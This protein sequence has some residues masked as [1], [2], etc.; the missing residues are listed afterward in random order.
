MTL[1]VRRFCFFADLVFLLFRFS[2][3]WSNL[4]CIIFTACDW[5]LF[6]DLFVTD[7]PPLSQP[8]ELIFCRFLYCLFFFT[9]RNASFSFNSRVSFFWCIHFA[10]MFI[11][12]ARLWSAWFSFRVSVMFPV[13][14]SRII[15]FVSSGFPFRLPAY[16]IEALGILCFSTPRHTVHKHCTGFYLASIDLLWLFHLGSLAIKALGADCL[17]CFTQQ[18]HSYGF[19]FR[20]AVRL[21]LHPSASP[22]FFVYC[23]FELCSEKDTIC[24]HF[25]FFPY[26]FDLKQLTF[27]SLIFSINILIYGALRKTYFFILSFLNFSALLSSTII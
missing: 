6:L 27:F 12:F 5:L 25:R 23:L 26:D 3:Q 2:L 9:S 7:V 17:F 14:V 15:W 22:R 13:S 4:F 19:R 11:H 24:F 10:V 1:F 20:C 18:F 16:F 8:A 21:L